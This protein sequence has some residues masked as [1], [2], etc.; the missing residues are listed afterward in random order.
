MCAS[1]RTGTS[2]LTAFVDSAQSINESPEFNISELDR[3]CALVI[4]ARP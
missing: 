1:L 4:I 3:R 2:L